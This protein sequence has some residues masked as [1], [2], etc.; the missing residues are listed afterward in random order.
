MATEKKAVERAIRPP[1][2]ARRRVDARF[3][4]GVEGLRRAHGG[5]LGEPRLVAASGRAATSGSSRPGVLG[6]SKWVLSRY[7]RR[8]PGAGSTPAQALAM[9][10]IASQK[11]RILRSERER[12]EN[13]LLTSTVKTHFRRLESAVESGDAD[14]DRR[15][16]QAAR[17]QDRQG[18][19]EGRHAQEHRR[20]QEVQSRP[21]R[22]RLGAPSEQPRRACT[23]ATEDAAMRRLRALAPSVSASSSP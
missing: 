10:N 1:W 2:R 12:T 6:V 3:L 23:R 16:A 13:R 9:A 4:A 15:R 11:K 18:H 21:A 8:P 14:D 22:R 19:S 5:V 7:S 17:L 20:P